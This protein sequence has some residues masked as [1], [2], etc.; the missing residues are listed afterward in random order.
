MFL[1]YKKADI[2]ISSF[3]KRS[4]VLEEKSIKLRIS[5]TLPK[6]FLLYKV[7]GYPQIISTNSPLLEIFGVNQ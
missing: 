5:L 2:A 4:R 3:K 7:P 6:N 1:E